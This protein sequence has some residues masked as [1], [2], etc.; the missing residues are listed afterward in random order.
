MVVAPLHLRVP[1]PWG[2]LTEPQGRAGRSGSL[3]EP[4]LFVDAIS[5][6]SYKTLRDPS[7]RTRSER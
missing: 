6:S 7:I 1:L 4:F 3:W 2:V 5:A